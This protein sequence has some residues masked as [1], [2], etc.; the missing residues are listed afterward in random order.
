MDVQY[1]G[2]YKQFI[3]GEWAEASNGGLWEVI[4]PATEEVVQTVPF[5]NGDDAVA[6]IEAAERAFPRW[7]GWTPYKRADILKKAADLMRSRAGDLAKITTQES[8]KPFAQAKG[9][10]IVAGDLFEWFAEECKRSYGRVIPAKRGNLRLSVIKQPLGVVG[11]ITA[12]NFPAYNPARAWAAALAA[13]CTVVVRPSE[14]TPLTAMEMV[15]ILVEAGVPAGVINLINGEPDAMGQAMLNHPACRK[16]SFTGST[17]VGKILMDG[18]SRTNTRLSLELGG[19]AP[20]L[21]FPDVNIE[22]VVAGAV[23]AKYRN[24]GQVCTAPQRFLVH[25]DIV[26]EFVD[27][28]VPAVEALKVGNG[29]EKGI[30]VGPLINAKQRERVERMVSESVIEGTQ[31]LVGGQRPLQMEKGYFYQPTVLFNLQHNQRVYHEE[32]FGPVMPIVPFSDA[33]EGI[34][35]ANST[36]YG[37]AAYVWTND[38]NTAVRVSEGLEFGIVGVNEWYPWAT[39]GPFPGWKQSGLGMESGEEGLHEYLETKLVAIGGLG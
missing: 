23:Q 4:N 19:N 38:L 27:R 30:D 6:A 24:N 1:Q 37:L 39:E 29:L 31:V 28:V 20:V 17:R 33:E 10:W 13:G 34:H 18:A 7:A 36:P 35:M 21:V 32:I 15:N 14:F 22:A 11:V 12:W 8:G 9:E 16:I 26:E 2:H 25:H 5:G 3:G